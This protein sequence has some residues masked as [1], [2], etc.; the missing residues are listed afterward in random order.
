MLE[1]EERLEREAGLLD[2][3]AFLEREDSPDWAARSRPGAG[4]PST[5]MASHVENCFLWSRH[6]ES[7][8]LVILLL[9]CHLLPSC[10]M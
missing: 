6:G 8:I 5:R 4:L 9:G 3:K 10:A 7:W 1:W 2:W